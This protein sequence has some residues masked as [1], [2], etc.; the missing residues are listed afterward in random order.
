M[1][2]E[3]WAMLPIAK[4]TLEQVSLPLYMSLHFNCSLLPLAMR[5]NG[6]SFF[7]F[8]WSYLVCLTRLVV[9]TDSLHCWIGSEEVI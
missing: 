1:I 8:F 9:V 5:S 3:L 2:S 7:V 4:T 6:F